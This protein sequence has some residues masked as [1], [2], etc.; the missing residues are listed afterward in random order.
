MRY[1]ARYI[2]RRK[3]APDYHRTIHADTLNEAIKQAE[4]YTRKGYICAGVTANYLT[5]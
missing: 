3:E 4:R 2:H 1:L 5:N